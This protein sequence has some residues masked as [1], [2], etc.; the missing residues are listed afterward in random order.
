MDRKQKEIELE[1][2]RILK[3]KL[4]VKADILE[5]QFRNLLFLNISYLYN[6]KK[7]STFS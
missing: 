7:S 2:D 6:F 5:R 1:K 4:Q 3:E